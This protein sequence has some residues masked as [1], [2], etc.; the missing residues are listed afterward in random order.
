MS[1]TTKSTSTAML[2][3]CLWTLALAASIPA[4]A[5]TRYIGNTM[6]EDAYLGDRQFQM[7]A[8]GAHGT[9][10]GYRDALGA[11]S[12]AGASAAAGDELAG[13]PPSATS[14]MLLAALGLL[15]MIARRRTFLR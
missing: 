7:L 1:G 10:A 14:G 15:G 2:R 5:T 3:V 11:T 9:D 8:L 4:Q 13:V 6:G 12:T